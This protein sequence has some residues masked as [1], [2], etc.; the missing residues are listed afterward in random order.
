MFQ[1]NNNVRR[2]TPMF[3]ELICEFFLSSR[4]VRE[5]F[6]F[7]DPPG[8]HDSLEESRVGVSRFSHWPVG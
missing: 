5:F 3:L 7:D 8:P 6:C 4:P 2:V 1:E